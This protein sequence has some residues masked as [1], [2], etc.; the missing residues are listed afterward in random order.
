MGTVKPTERFENG[1]SDKESSSSIG[2]GNLDTKELS[3]TAKDLSQF[4][5]RA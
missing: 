4:L 1:L 2:L 5:D 3:K